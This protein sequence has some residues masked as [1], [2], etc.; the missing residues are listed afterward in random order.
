M[1]PINEILIA[2][3]VFVVVFISA[4]L[5]NY[6]FM[7]WTSFSVSNGGTEP[8]EWKV[9]NGYLTDSALFKDAIFTITDGNGKVYTQDVSNILEN[10]ALAAGSFKGSPNPIKLDFPLNPFS[11]IITGVNDINAIPDLATKMQPKWV[12]ATATL[13][14]KIK[15]V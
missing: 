9:P 15:F 7:N 2:F 5:I 12:N 1:L 8:K 4:I 10:M 3:F 13:T 14:G 11:F 6:H